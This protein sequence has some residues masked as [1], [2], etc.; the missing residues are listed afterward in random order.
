MADENVQETPQEETNE[1]P[2]KKDKGGS[3][4]PWVIIA[5]VV[6]VSS[7]AG[8][9]LGLLFA[10]N[11]TSTETPAP[12]Q[13]QNTVAEQAGETDLLAEESDSA[14]VWYY[15]M[16][17][18]VA[19]LDEPRATRYVRAAF[20]LEMSAEITPDKGTAF[21]ESKKPILTNVLT[22]YLAGLNVEASRGDRNLKRIQSDIRDLFNERLFPDSKPFIKRILIKE[23]A[24]Q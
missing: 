12:P 14:S 22:I 19:N 8:I 2:A 17:P 21:I 15:D 16:E 5:V 1:A 9:G 11:R 7:G 24:V 18:V 13:D 3:I 20:T 4:V 10:G 6:L 23:F